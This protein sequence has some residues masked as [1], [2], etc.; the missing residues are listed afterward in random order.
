MNTIDPN[1]VELDESLVRQLVAIRRHLHRHPE[2]SFQEHA[3]CSYIIERLAAWGI[4]YQRIGDTGVFVDIIG[5][6][7]D[8]PHIGIRADIDA[9]PIEERTGLPFAS[10]QP[11]VMH[12]CGHDGHTTI[13]LGTVFQLNRLKDR[14]SGRVRCVFQP[15]E[16]LEGAAA[17]LIQ[18]GVLDNPRV[19]AMLA[20]HLWP[21]LPFGT[22]GVK[23]GTITAS[24]DDFSM[25]ILGKGGHSARPHQGI[26][27]IAVSGHLLQAISLLVTKANNPVDPVVVHVGKIQGGTASNVIADR[28]VMEGTVRA[29]TQ[30]TRERV[31][32]Q[33]QSLAENVAK[34][35]GAKASIR[36]SDGYCPV[37]NDERV[38]GMLEQSAKVLLG[39]GHVH[40]LPVPSMGADDFGAFA[41]QVPSSYFR[42]GIRQADQPCFDLHHPE[43]Q[44]ADEI[45][46]VGVRV[47]TWTV[48]NGLQKGM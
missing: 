6:S 29:L 32:Q 30:E 16:E 26:D 31:K 11:G 39:A 3:T 28:V 34:T 25:E 5:E 2:L 37:V 42:L 14:L 9:L 20:L 36:Y 35:Y 47:F 10:E 19:D 38:T 41:E 4:P 15:G 21:H 43:F 48:L 7:G 44:F 18:L 17:Q 12:A 23:Y 27:A 13:L 8:G 1:D 46:P 45:I 33:L 24:C 40:V 22:I